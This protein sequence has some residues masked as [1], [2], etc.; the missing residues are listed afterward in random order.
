MGYINPIIGNR[1][2]IYTL[3]E[4]FIDYPRM[5][6]TK[7]GIP[8]IELNWIGI[9]ENV[10]KQVNSLKDKE[11]I[12]KFAEGQLKGSEYEAAMVA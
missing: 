2:A 12:D 6:I 1:H 8:E 11:K 4:D 7:N 10:Y 9:T 3:K 5:L